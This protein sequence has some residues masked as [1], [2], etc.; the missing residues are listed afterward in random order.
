LPK[1]TT[2]PF[3]TATVMWRV[4]V[5]THLYK[6]WGE[7]ACHNPAQWPDV[8][9]RILAKKDHGWHL[10]PEV[11]KAVEALAVLYE[12]RP[13][14]KAIDIWRCWPKLNKNRCEQLAELLAGVYS[15]RSGT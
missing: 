12:S 5:R 1:K 2:D 8:L 6:V 9:E 7:Q 15:D 10:A 14:P 13:N 3:D 4:A 11:D